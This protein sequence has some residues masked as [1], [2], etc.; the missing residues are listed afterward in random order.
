MMYDYQEVLEQLLAKVNRLD[1]TLTNLKSNLVGDEPVAS[2]FVEVLDSGKVLVHRRA[3]DDVV[4]EELAVA[5]GVLA[6]G[7]RVVRRKY[8]TSAVAVDDLRRRRRVASVER[9]S[10]EIIFAGAGDAA[11]DVRFVT[12]LR[13][14]GRQ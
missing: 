3:V 14:V 6:G 10:L 12:G 2:P 7:Q 11:G 4:E 8:Q 9:V 1:A 5:V 13:R